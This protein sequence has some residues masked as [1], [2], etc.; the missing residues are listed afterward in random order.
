VPSHV[1][2]AYA[3]GSESIDSEQ[4]SSGNDCQI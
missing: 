1:T 2:L 4:R 3:R